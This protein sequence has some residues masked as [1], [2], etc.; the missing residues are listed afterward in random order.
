M[1]V[2]IAFLMVLSTAGATM[3]QQP[4]GKAEPI[5]PPAGQV[6]TDFSY[7]DYWG[8]TL[9]SFSLDLIEQRLM[10]GLTIH[11]GRIIYVLE[12]KAM[13]RLQLEPLKRSPDAIL[14][15]FATRKRRAQWRAILGYKLQNLAQGGIVPSK[16]RSFSTIRASPRT[17]KKLVFARSPDMPTYGVRCD[18]A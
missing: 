11:F 18:A 14:R 4:K 13:C 8:L 12:F 3:G 2:V 17:T 16:S 10:D 7:F 5:P 15:L 9:K 1:R 6:K